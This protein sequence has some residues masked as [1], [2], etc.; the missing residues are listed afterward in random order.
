M[1]FPDQAAA[2]E[3]HA[4]APGARRPSS[5]WPGPVAA[6]APGILC[7]PPDFYWC[8]C[9]GVAN[10]VCCATADYGG[11]GCSTQFGPCACNP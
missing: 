1:K 5:A 8:Y 3:R 6:V 10:P 7:N 11:N 2:V 9:P 4:G